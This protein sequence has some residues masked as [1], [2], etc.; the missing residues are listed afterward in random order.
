MSLH[1][2]QEVS[3]THGKFLIESSSSSSSSGGGGGLG[4]I[5]GNKFYFMD[6]GST[7]G[8]TLT[9]GGDKVEPNVKIELFD[10]MELCVGNST[11]KIIM[12]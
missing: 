7:N 10:G 1:K 4:G 2:D 8:T 5:S 6:V 11:L 9:V 3:T 12:G